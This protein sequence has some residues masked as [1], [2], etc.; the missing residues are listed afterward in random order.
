MD[1]TVIKNTQSQVWNNTEKIDAF[2]SEYKI[3]TNSAITSRTLD[4]ETHN[5]LV[6]RL[7]NDSATSDNT[8]WDSN[9]TK[10]TSKKRSSS[11]HNSIASLSSVRNIKSILDTK[12]NEKIGLVLGHPEINV[13]GNTTNILTGD[14]TPSITDLTD[15]ES[16]DI[17]MG[18]IIKTFTIQNIGTSN[19]SV[20]SI[21]ASGTDF[22]IT[23]APNFPATVASA[24]ST[25]FSVTFNPATIG[26]KTSTITINNN[27]SDEGTYT[28]TIQGTGT[29]TFYDSDGD[30]VYDNLDIDDDN[31]GIKDDTEEINCESLSANRV[32]YKFLNETFGTGSRT[33][34]NT[35]Y[36]AYSSYCYEDGSAGV[37]T[38]ECPD[39]ST[40]DL[41][42]GKYTVGPSAQI[43]SWAASYWYTG[44]DH[45]T[46]TDPNGRMAM[47]NASYTPGIFYTAL[48]TGALPNIPI[49]Y[50]FW[51]LNLD[52]TDAPG[53]ATRLRPNIKVEFRDL[54]DVVLA[55]IT[56]NAINADGNWHQYTSS[57]ITLNVSAFKV[58]FIN[59]ETG[60]LG[61][62]LALDDI[63][64]TQTL[65]DL[66]YDGVADLFDLDSD[67]DGIEDV[68]EVGLGNISNGKGKISATWVDANGNGLHD[69]AEATA[70]LPALDSDGDG[71]PNYLDLDSD[72]DSIFDVDESGAGNTN[73]VTGYQNGD[74]DINGDGRG[75]GVESEVFRSK[76]TNGDGIVEGFGDGILDIY[77]Y[78]VVSGATTSISPANFIIAYGNLN[79]GTTISPFLNYLLDTDNDGIPDYI[80][81]KSDGVTFDISKT[82]YASLD[83]DG[84]GII[85]GAT[86]I[87]KD[88]IRDSFDTNTAYFGS[89]RN[90]NR[91]LYLDFD[92]RN[93]Y[94]QN[95]A[96]LGGL[97]NATLMAWIDLNSSFSTDGVVIGQDKFQIRITNNK[98]LEAVV[99][100][101]TVSYA[102]ALSTSRW[103]HVGAIY[104]GATIKLFLNGAL[105]ATQTKTGNISADSS[106]LTLGKDPLTN[107]KYF[108]GKIDEVRVFNT[109]LTN[110]QLQRI[111]Y[112]EIDENSTQLKGAIVPKEIAKANETAVSFAN[113]IRYYRMDTYKDDVI[114]DMSTATIDITG[115]KIYNHK[116]IYAQEAPMPFLTERT[117]DFATA[118]NSPT[119]EIRGMDVM[120]QDW[121]IIKVQHDITEITNNVDLAMIIDSG[122]NVT[123]NN[124]TKIQN[125][126][127]LKLNGK[128][129]LTGMSQLVQTTNSDLDVTSTGYIERDQQGQKNKYNYN[130]WSAPVSPINATANNSNY[131]IAGVMKDGTTSTPQNISW[132][133]GY[134]GAST[135]PISLARYWIYKF[136]NNTD[137]YAN[138]IQINENSS[139][140]VGQ[141]YTL[142]GSGGSGTQNY[143]FVGKPN[144]GTITTNSVSPDQLLLI[145][146]PY[147]S[148]IDANQFITDN[149]N[150]IDQLQDVGIDGTL[151]FWEHSS[152]NNSHVLS[153]YLGGYS[154]RNLTGGLPPVVPDY[155]NG[156][157]LS[158]KI[159]NQ[160][161]PVGQGFFVYGKALSGGTIVFNNAQRSFVKETEANS[162]TLFKIN[163]DS[164][165]GKTLPINNSS[166]PVKK[167]TNITI[168][169]GYDSANKSHRQVLLAFMNEKATSEIDYGYDAYALDNFPNDMFLLNDNEQLVIEG[170]GYFDINNSYPIG[171]KANKEGEV[172]FNIDAIENV[173]PEQ[174]IFIYDDESKTYND[175][176][177]KPYKTNLPVSKNNTRFSLR[178]TDKTLGVDTYNYKDITI[179]YTQ[180]NNTLTI[181]NKKTDMVVEKVTVFNIIGQAIGTW[182][183]DN[184][185]QKNIQI[186]FNNSSTGVY[187]AKIKTTT[188]IISKKFILK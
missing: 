177:T 51:V 77:D 115:T 152:N 170:E 167:N 75:D 124:D 140:R 9:N 107:T 117:G 159:P 147:P 21:T 69:S 120:D 155:I 169:L 185:D 32:N 46:P 3:K 176:R 123:M 127:Y 90:L 100:G 56:T 71:V 166:D 102:T 139:L 43:A 110:S 112:Q 8:S 134:N 158:D 61:N 118:V 5:N 85:N 82:L 187:I 161:I 10:I 103:Y 91:K 111:V 37:N 81:V 94:G 20:M 145:G 48:I 19:L 186:P 165:T 47:F 45:T 184:Q 38:P 60:G 7:K 88:G 164:K 18:T 122:K 131:T 30:G 95:T 54:N 105:V 55:T 157:G 173:D 62:D 108:K 93:D 119:K 130:Y 58:I 39:L 106:L 113:M 40:T 98:K 31:D 23:T 70:A 16:V 138:W 27:D 78:G 156:V 34:I 183:V 29:Q 28:F 153:S 83:T 163:S 168:R 15:F 160:F 25:T 129:D 97:A 133:S 148:A 13:Q 179:L 72:N 126:W 2:S 26:L 67:N 6:T 121:S 96:I 188:G 92:G 128:I 174:P 11:I 12:K 116:N 73:A 144:N 146:N 4:T 104:D 150:S 57:T 84:D 172:S 151:Y 79:Q 59:N 17:S 52:R 180:N 74:G 41:N 87:D 35:T 162:N 86:D 125:D 53:V 42:D 66:D 178:F 14:T 50:S 114:D 36:N 64:I 143:T 181:N 109:A 22:S 154:I 171:V 80:D 24:S 135:S 141:G 182:K 132:I 99:N 44:N 65:C 137:S 149:M 101:T 142:K 68:V 63:T 136:E 49:T 33:T 76:D 1:Q 175:I 89:P